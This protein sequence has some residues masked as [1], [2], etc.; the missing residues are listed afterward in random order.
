MI[1]TVLEERYKLIKE[2]GKGGT[3]V[4]YLAKDL[5][6]GRYWAVKCISTDQNDNFDNA[7]K[8]EVD[9][10]S[11]LNHPDIPRIVQYIKTDSH[12]YVVMDYINGI[13]LDEK[14][15]SEGVQDEECVILWARGLCDILTYL[16]TAKTCPIIYCDLKPRN[17][18]VVDNRPKLID[19]GIAKMCDQQVPTVGKAIGT[20]GYAPPEQYR[21]GSNILRPSSDMYSL[22]A[23]MYKL[24][25]NVTLKKPNK[26]FKNINKYNPNISEE[27]E[28][29]IYKCLKNNPLERYQTALELKEDL[30]KLRTICH[31]PRERVIKQITIT[32]ASLFLALFFTSMSVFGYHSMQINKVV[33]YQDYYSEGV[34]YEQEGEFSQALEEYLKAIRTQPE[35]GELYKRLYDLLKPD[36]TALDYN[37]KEKELLDYFKNTFVIEYIVSDPEFAMQI[38]KDTIALNDP[39]YIKYAQSLIESI[40]ET[41][42]YRNEIV[43]HAEVKTLEEM[44]TFN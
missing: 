20:D 17:I 7:I 39:N 29:I 13:T 4:V 27:L 42:A 14:L 1:D 12:I 23:T 30:D 18:M 25:T 24:L 16:H 33:L 34:K 3:S 43:D 10:L 41:E 36:A 26:P 35:N 37:L 31:E 40:K 11:S 5:Q 2:I 8:K 6:L 44:V 22:G 19:F 15:K 38:L 9:L 28:Q 32:A 21:N